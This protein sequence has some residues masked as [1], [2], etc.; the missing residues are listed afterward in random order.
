MLLLLLT[1]NA[2]A[3]KYEKRKT[4]QSTRESNTFFLVPSP[5]DTNPLKSRS[6][7][8]LASGDVLCM[9]SSDRVSKSWEEGPAERTACACKFF[10]LFL[11]NVWKLTA[12]GVPPPGVCTC[13][14]A[15]IVQK[16]KKK[17]PS[18]KTGGEGRRVAKKKTTKQT[19]EQPA[20]CEGCSTRSWRTASH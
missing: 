19:T 3:S 8:C 17:E 7:C 16:K 18:G 1:F 14:A 15:C 2:T 20:A 5:S 9:C 6:L 13:N 10:P 12:F 11:E 4:A